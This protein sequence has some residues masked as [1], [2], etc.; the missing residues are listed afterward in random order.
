MTLVVKSLQ[1]R[2]AAHEYFLILILHGGEASARLITSAMLR[3]GDPSQSRTLWA[4]IA[5]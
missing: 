5:P 2:F 3:C 1:V 4:V